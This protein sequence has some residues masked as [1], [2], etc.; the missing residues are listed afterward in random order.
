M[1]KEYFEKEYEHLFYDLENELTKVNRNINQIDFLKNAIFNLYRCA[2][3]FDFDYFD[4][5]HNSYVSKVSK[6]L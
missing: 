2:I 4:N 3:L 5:L 6:Y 1:N